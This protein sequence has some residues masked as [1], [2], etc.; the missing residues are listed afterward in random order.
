MVLLALKW[1]HPTPQQ[2]TRGTFG[3]GLTSST[4]AGV[5]GTQFGART[6]SLTELDR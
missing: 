5:V 1:A 4:A 2:Q 6:C 3:V